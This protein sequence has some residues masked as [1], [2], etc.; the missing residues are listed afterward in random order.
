M[1]VLVFDRLFEQH[2]RES[3]AVAWPH[4]QDEVWD[5]VLVFM[6]DPDKEH[7]KIVKDLCAALAVVADRAAGNDVLSGA[8][9]SDLGAEWKTNYRQPDVAVYLAA[10]PA[11]KRATHW[12]GGPDVAVE[13]VAL[14]E[15]P[16]LK[17]HFYARTNSR[18]V[19]IVDRYP[20]VV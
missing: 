14:F 5:S 18:E 13:V 12:V 6:P 16:R 4:D 3:R 20:W 11:Q 8:N 9:V 1:P 17:L 7:R 10:N 19:L 2:I 15:D